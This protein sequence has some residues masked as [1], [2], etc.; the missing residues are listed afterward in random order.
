MVKGVTYVQLQHV[1]WEELLRIS[2]ERVLAVVQ[3]PS[4]SIQPSVYAV[5]GPRRLVVGG[6]RR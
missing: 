4:P 3:G 5:F 6:V 1:V 2:V